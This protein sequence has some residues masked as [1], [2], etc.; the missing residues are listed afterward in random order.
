MYNYYKYTINNI[1]FI[2]T[3][4]SD[5]TDVDD[6]KVDYPT[7][8]NATPTEGEAVQT[9]GDTPETEGDGG[10][11]AD[12]LTKD[13]GDPT[14]VFGEPTLND[15]EPILGESTPAVNDSVSAP[16]TVGLKVNDDQLP[17]SP[18]KKHNI[19]T[20][21]Y[22]CEQYASLEQ[23]YI[24]CR[25]DDSVL[26]C[27]SSASKEETILNGLTGKE[28]TYY[29]GGQVDWGTRQWKCEGTVLPAP[30]VDGLE[31][32]NFFCLAVISGAVVP[33][34]YCSTERRFICEN[35]V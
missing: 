2:Q 1:V 27:M 23:A 28:N 3:R 34:P 16:G 20:N 18:S 12:D 4:F 24:S 29:I 19:T 5:A 35:N 17:C 14:V 11:P 31:A 33:T 7:S 32:D 25:A 30:S 8:D 9:N 15:S 22:F 21:V 26:V 13:S 6:T 10:Q